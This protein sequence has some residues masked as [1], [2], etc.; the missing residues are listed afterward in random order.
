MSNLLFDILE[1]KYTP[2]EIQQLLCDYDEDQLKDY[3]LGH[4][5]CPLCGSS[6]FIHRWN[7]DRGE[8]WGSK[9]HEEMTELKCESCGETY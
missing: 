6:L 9:C 2:E 8:F 4:D 7:E 3:C 1:E 5:I